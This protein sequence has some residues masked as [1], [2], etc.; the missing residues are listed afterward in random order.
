METKGVSVVFHI[1]CNE[2]FDSLYIDLT[3]TVQIKMTSYRCE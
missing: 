3:A 1:A 2:K